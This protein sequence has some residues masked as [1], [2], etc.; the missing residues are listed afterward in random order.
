MASR[1]VLIIGIIIFTLAVTFFVSHFAFTMIQTKLLLTAEVNQS[2][3]AKEMVENMSNVTSRMDFVIMGAFIG[4]I[5]F[6]LISSWFIGGHPI[7]M[8]VHFIFM[9]VTIIVGAVLSNVWESV[10]TNGTFGVT[11]AAFPKTNYLMTNLPVLMAVL[12]FIGLVVMF[13]KPY[14]S[15]SGGY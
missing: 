3:V 9:V 14:L 10:V 12:G 4:Y 13:G 8:A 2:T 7:F 15:Q 6:L 1:D 5:I 11:L